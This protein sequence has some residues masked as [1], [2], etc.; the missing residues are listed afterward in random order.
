MAVGSLSE[1]LDT[2]YTSTWYHRRGKVADNY[3]DAYPLTAWLRSS[4]RLKRLAGGRR[5]EV[6]LE[7]AENDQVSWI[8]KG[9]AVTLQDYEYLTVALYYWK[10]QV[11][12]IVRFGVDDQQNRSKMAAINIMDTKLRNSRKAL[13]K[14]M[15]TKLF[16]AA[17]SGDEI[18]GLQHLVQ[19]DPTSSTSVGGINQATYTWWANKTSNMTGKSSASYLTARMRTMLNN[20]SNNNGQEG[21]DII[22][23]GQN[24]YEYYEDNVLDFY[25]VQS[26]KMGDLGFQNIMFKGIPMFW[27]PSCGTRMYFLNTEYISLVY[28][29][30]WL[31]TMTPWKDIP[32]QPFDRAA[33]IISAF[34]YTTSRRRAQGV[35]YNIDTE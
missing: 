18:D 15:E 6:P 23:T 10:Y 31:L 26:N 30:M 32:A 9:A 19:D 5:I 7:Y 21:P 17:A 3:F 4:G 16:A 8:T 11:A 25:R 14:D 12:S 24:P 22:I 27:S 34:A 33:Q 20:V 29:P 35:I 28:D 2:L 1:T 13:T